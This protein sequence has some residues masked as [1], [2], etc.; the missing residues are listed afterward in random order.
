MRP[1]ESTTDLDEGRRGFAARAWQRAYDGLLAAQRE[2]PLAPQDLWRLALASYLVGAEADFTRALQEAHQAHAD[3]G[4]SLEAV[5]AAFWL[6]QHL[7]SKGEFARGS[8]WFARAARIVE[9]DEGEGA[10]RGYVLLQSAY[11]S[12]IQGAYAASTE[13]SVEATSVG[14]RFGDKD[15]VALAIHVQGRAL[16]RLGRLVEGLA[17]L[18]EAMLAV[19]SDELSPVATGLIYCS[20]L[21]ACREVDALRRAQEWTEALSDWCERQPDMVAYS[22]ECLVSR[23]E[24][25]QR[26]GEWGRA[27]DELQLALD[28]FERGSGL[29]SAGPAFYQQGEVYRLRGEFAAAEQAYHAASRAGRGPQPGLALLR[30]SQG[31]PAAASAALRRALAEVRDPLKRAKLL[32]SLT[33][34]ALELGDVDC[35]IEA[36]DELERIAAQWGGG[37]LD[38][39][40]AHAR[41]AIELAS[42]VAEKALDPLRRALRAWDTMGVPYEAARVRVLLATACRLL[43]DEE[44]AEME[45]QAAR[46][47]LERLGAAPALARLEPLPGRSKARDHG[48]TPREQEV[49]S[50]LATGLTNRAIGKKL[51]ISEKTVARHVANIYGKLGLSSRAAATAYAYEHD[52]LDSGT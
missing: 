49:L 46:A 27:L 11:Q 35:A 26:R 25:H 10:G 6:G 13:A 33:E 19:T 4:E 21:G 7:A 22:G 9:G 30:L 8:G 28:R 51:F 1:V 38:A 24:I 43:G 5:R 31:D 40:A 37:V 34:S 36:C 44:G 42:G 47:E 39:V 16:L 12:L 50:W 17:A 32:P 48:L 29:G 15:L 14:Q 41:G 20:V 45:L 2:R 23:A 52:L 3:A 18:D